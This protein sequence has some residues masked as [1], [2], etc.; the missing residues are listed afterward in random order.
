ML[1]P[2]RCTTGRP[3]SHPGC[4]ALVQLGQVVHIGGL[5]YHT[6]HLERR[7]GE[8]GRGERDGGGGEGEQEERRERETGIRQRRR[9]V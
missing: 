4:P 1:E 6:V 7:G 5:L 8:T 9:K 2:K 3:H